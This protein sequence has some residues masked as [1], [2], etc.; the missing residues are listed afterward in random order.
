MS[1]GFW[2]NLNAFLFPPTRKQSVVQIVYNSLIYLV[3]VKQMSAWSKYF[4]EEDKIGASWIRHYL[5]KFL[6]KPKN[7]RLNVETIL[8]SLNESLITENISWQLHKDWPPVVLEMLGVKEKTSSEM[9][10]VTWRTTTAVQNILKIAFLDLTHMELE[11]WWL[12]KEYSQKWIQ[13]PKNPYFNLNFVT[14]FK[15]AH[16]SPLWRSKGRG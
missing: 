5:N 9:D 12:K 13:R 16:F 8:T 2:K 14:K 7:S 10:S 3:T 15:L 6:Y 11:K 4:R 1:C